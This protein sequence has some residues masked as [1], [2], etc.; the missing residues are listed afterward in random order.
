MNR[1]IGAG[2]GHEEAHVCEIEHA[3]PAGKSTSVGVEPATGRIVTT[4]V[5]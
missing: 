1:D 2:I 5:S 3:K 4:A